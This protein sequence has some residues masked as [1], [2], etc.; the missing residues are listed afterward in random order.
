MA[1][2]SAVLHRL[3]VVR[4][5]KAL[6]RRDLEASEARAAARGAKA[7]AGREAMQAALKSLDREQRAATRQVGESA[8]AVSALTAEVAQLT[9]AFRKLEGRALALEQV[10]ERD[11]RQSS[12]L[13]AFRCSVRSG[14]VAHHVA[15]SL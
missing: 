10:I 5:L 7:D 4:Q 3:G 13:E 6:W 12:V 14:T 8:A 11:R 15:A 2:V 1:V 9:E